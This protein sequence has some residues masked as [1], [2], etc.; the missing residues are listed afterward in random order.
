[1][2]DTIDLDANHGIVATTCDGLSVRAGWH[3]P[4]RWTGFTPLVHFAVG[5]HHPA[6]DYIDGDEF[7]FLPDH[8]YRL[9]KALIKAA[10]E[11]VPHWD[12][13]N[14]KKKGA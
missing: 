1:M 11:S 14:E 6:E 13:E 4:G 12:F 9:G 5:E 7:T 2:T 8:A 10:E 3:Q